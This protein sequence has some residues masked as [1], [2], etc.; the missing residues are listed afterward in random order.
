MFKVYQIRLSV[1]LSSKFF[2]HCYP[3]LLN[4]GKLNPK[5]RIENRKGLIAELERFR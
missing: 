3:K 5:P 4:S 1:Y 2:M